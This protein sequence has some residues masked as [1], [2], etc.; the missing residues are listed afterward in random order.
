MN[1]SLTFVS[2]EIRR[3]SK[4]DESL[5]RQPEIRGFSVNDEVEAAPAVR[6]LQARACLHLPAARLL[7]DDAGSRGRT[8]CCGNGGGRGSGDGHGKTVETARRR[9]DVAEVGVRLMMI[10]PLPSATARKLVFVRTNARTAGAKA[11]RDG[12][13][14]NHAFSAQEG[15]LVDGGR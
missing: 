12:R 13:N 9:R 6:P 5:P 11:A 8:R 2:F 7:G 3:I 10:F 4:S 15:R 14:E 1:L